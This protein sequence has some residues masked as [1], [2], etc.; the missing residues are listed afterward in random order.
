MAKVIWKGA[1]SFSLIHIPVSLYPASRPASLD[2]TMLDK[3]DFSPVGYQRINKSTGKTVE[4]DD[5]VKGYE[6]EKGEYV[7]LSDEDFR[8]ANVEATQTIDIQGFVEP[9]EIP[10]MFYDTPYYLA[11]DKR[12]E[13]VYTL[14]R[15]ALVKSNTVAIGLIVLR[16]KQYVC[17]LLPVG[18]TLLLNTLRYADEVLKPEEHA[19]ATRTLED[20]RVSQR[21]FGMALK[22][23]EDMKQKWDPEACHDTYREDLLRRV[24]E[25]VQAGKTKTLTPAAAKASATRTADVLDLTELLKRSLDQ[26]GGGRG[27]RGSRRGDSAPRANAAS[28][29]V[30]LPA[31]TR[32]ASSGGTKRRRSA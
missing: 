15:E 16:T 18:D 7:V 23:V 29:P 12:G 19:P 1:V 10:P 20:A 30:V 26:R 6:Y 14:L 13:K 22:L 9:A 28:E 5:V 4:W 17:A 31:R 11:A 2:L 25:K 3:R 24:D 8:Q 32:K 21:E 27:A